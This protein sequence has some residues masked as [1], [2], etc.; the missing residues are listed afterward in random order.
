MSG[1]EEESQVSGSEVEQSEVEQSEV[2]QEVEFENLEGDVDLDSLTKK[3]RRKA[4]YRQRLLHCFQKYSNLLIITVDNVGSNQLQQVRIALR[5]KAEILMGKNTVIRKVIRDYEEKFPH[6]LTLL[7]LIRGNMGFVFCKDSLSEVR[8]MILDNKVPA[9][10]RSGAIA[11]CDVIIPPG[12]TGLDPGQ[13]SFFQALN[14]ATKISR[15]AI[16]ITNPVKLILTGDKVTASHVALLNKLNIRPFFYSIAVTQAFDNGSLYD[17]KVLDISEADIMSRLF[18]GMRTIAALSMA[19]G[20]PTGASVPHSMINTFKN[21]CAIS[22]ATGFAFEETKE[23]IALLN[24]PEA[25]K[26]AMEANAGGDSEEDEDEDEEEEEDE[27]SEGG[28]GDMF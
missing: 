27:E 5:G 28:L 9:G 26:A 16:E 8:K 21:V 10:A 7:P 22:L 13:T 17:A 2:E 18:Q 1:S 15:G 12:S 11:P 23:W 3:K 19:C 6:L 20:H 25:L 24:D 14:I 4:I